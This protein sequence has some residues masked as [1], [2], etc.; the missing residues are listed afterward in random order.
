MAEAALGPHDRPTTLPEPTPRMGTKRASAEARGAE[1]PVVASAPSGPT[2]ELTSQ[3]ATFAG[4]GD[5]AVEGRMGD[6]AT[7]SPHLER[8]LA[9]PAQGVVIGEASS[10]SSPIGKHEEEVTI[11]HPFFSPEQAEYEAAKMAGFDDLD[12]KTSVLSGTEPGV[13][14]ADGAASERTPMSPRVRSSLENTGGHRLLR[15][16][17]QRE[18]DRPK[19]M[20]PGEEADARETTAPLARSGREREAGQNGAPVEGVTSYRVAIEAR[21]E[22]GVRLFALRPGEMPEADQAT[23]FIVP[24]DAA[25]SEVIAALLSRPNKA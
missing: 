21:P 7:T 10:A 25:S 9:V 8:E 24:T 11:Q 12:E 14:L 1:S 2:R 15:T 19:P 13:E 22:G 5:L 4:I 3:N 18:T 23:A 20:P 17:A 16:R 6:D